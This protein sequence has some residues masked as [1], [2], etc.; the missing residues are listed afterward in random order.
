ME[1][2]VLREEDINGVLIKSNNEDFKIRQ[3]YLKVWELDGAIYIINVQSLKSRKIVE[4][5]KVKKYVM[6]EESSHD[7]KIAFDWI[8]A[9]QLIKK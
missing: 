4:F 8:V 9:K 2:G 6:D 5:K 1:K 7:I 3:D